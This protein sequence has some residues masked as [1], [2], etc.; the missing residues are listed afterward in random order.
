MYPRGLD[1]AIAVAIRVPPRRSD[2]TGGQCPNGN[3]AVLELQS[4]SRAGHRFTIAKDRSIIGR[5]PGCDIVLEDGAVSRQHAVVVLSDGQV[6]I[7]DLRSRNG[8]AVNGR[9]VTAP[10]KLEHGDEIQICGQRLI[11]SRPPA[12][13]PFD[14]G[15]HTIM[16]DALAVAGEQQDEGSLILSQVDLSNPSQEIDLG[17]HSEKKLRAVL[18]LNRAIGSSLSLDEV[19]PRM[20]D[21]LLEIFPAADRVFVLLKDAQSRRLVLRARKVR[22]IEEPGPLRLSLSLINRVAQTQRAIL[23]ADAASDSRFSAAESLVNCRIRSVMCVPVVTGDGTLLGVV[24]LDSR[25]I[26]DGFGGD[27]LEVLAGIA[28]QAAQAIEHAVAYDER[29]Q[30][31]QLNRDLEL[32]HRVQQGLLPSRPPEIADYEVY[33]YYEAARHVGGDFFTY[34]PLPDGRM[35]FVLA[36]VS[37]KGVAAALLMA[38]LS[39]DIRYCLASER[40]VAKAASRLNEN[41]L[42]GGWDDRFATMIIVVL[43]PT[44]HKA[45]ICNAGH[46]PVFVRRAVGKVEMIGADLGGLPLGMDPNCEYRSC[47]IDIAAGDALLVFTDGIS[48]A[49]DHESECYGFER[50][51]KV[52]AGPG[53]SAEDIGTRLLTDV[54][55]FSAGQP[56]SDDICLVCIRRVAAGS[57][58]PSQSAQ[59]TG[60]AR[61]GGRMQA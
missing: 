9:P 21:G 37:G 49:M 25:D 28:G 2:S 52:L 54:E 10:R 53:T 57:K 34:V 33:D 20:L 46:L 16:G 22:G 61:R 43:E 1:R 41:F 4:G 5:H 6:T 14:E 3:V 39:A 45:T 38:A 40:D 31:E 32:A 7:E 30:R 58:P 60:S 13:Q 19:L 50:L 26:S 17:T 35:A 8:T 15:Q 56:Q 18:G 44:Q 51:E 36:D 23:S 12:E 42:R 48:E 24:Q 47:T 27:D 59:R 29:I 55:R 11:F